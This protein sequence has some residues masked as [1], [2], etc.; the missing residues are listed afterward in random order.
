MTR[1]PIQNVSVRRQL[2]AAIS[3]AL[4]VTGLKIGQCKERF[5]RCC[6]CKKQPSNTCAYWIFPKT[7][8]QVS[9]FARCKQ[10]K[11]FEGDG[12][13]I[14]DVPARGEIDGFSSNG[15]LLAAAFFRSWPDPFDLG[16]PSK[17]LRVAIYD[18]S[19]KSERCSVPLHEPVS[20]WYSTRFYDLS[21]AGSLALAQQNLLSLYEP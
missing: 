4:G 3:D 10:M 11:V 19:M 20:S 16:S 6:T 18:L 21:T 17:P 7:G 9:E 2:A 14:W 12:T 13:V 1:A 8:K 15:V 5:W